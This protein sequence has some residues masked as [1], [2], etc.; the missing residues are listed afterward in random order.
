M[1]D[2][3]TVAKPHQL[4][5]VSMH[6]FN[7]NPKNGPQFFCP[8]FFFS[9]VKSTHTRRILCR[10]SGLVSTFFSNRDKS[11]AKN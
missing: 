6:K 11:D 3:T 9:K 7:H 2:E 1:T 8:S 5:G 10:V 4:D